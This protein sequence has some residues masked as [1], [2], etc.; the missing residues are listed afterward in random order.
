M[1]DGL[2]F[3]QEFLS[4]ETQEQE[5]PGLPSFEEE[6]GVTV[7]VA[8]GEGAPSA[9]AVLGALQRARRSL[10]L[11]PTPESK[12]FESTI[13]LAQQQAI[14]DV[15]AFGEEFGVDIE[16]PGIG[17][18]A[19]Q[20]AGRVLL[21]GEN[22]ATG[23]NKNF[24]ESRQRAITAWQ[25][26]RHV[27][28]FFSALNA[29]LSFVPGL[30]PFAAKRAIDAVIADETF[31]DTALFREIKDS[32]PKGDPAADS[33]SQKF[34]NLL[35]GAIELAGSILTDPTT[36]I[37]FGT[38]GA[39][40]LVAQGAAKGGKLSKFGTLVGKEV[41]LKK[42]GK[43]LL[44][45]ELDKLVPVL[46]KQYGLTKE[47]ADEMIRDQFANRLQRELFKRAGI[48]LEVT[49]KSVLE[50]VED[51][52]PHLVELMTTRGGNR[53]VGNFYR[54]AKEF[55]DDTLFKITQ[56]VETASERVLL[57]QVRQSLKNLNK[58]SMLERG[59]IPQGA[60]EKTIA[61]ALKREERRLIA[62]FA[63]EKAAGGGYRGMSSFAMNTTMKRGV[64]K[65]LE[66]LIDKDPSLIPRLMDF[67]GLKFF[68][69]TL[70]TTEQLAKLPFV[71]SAIRLGQKFTPFKW[72]GAIFKFDFKS[73][74]ELRFINTFEYHGPLAAAKR[75]VA[76]A[77]IDLYKT[78]D[79]DA[80]R[81]IAL[82]VEDTFE[83][84]IAKDQQGRKFLQ[85]GRV[86]ESAVE[87]IAKLA[88]E[89]QR[90]ANATKNFF[91]SARKQELAL[92]IN[93]VDQLL[94]D[95][96]SYMFKT[97]VSKAFGVKEFKE[98]IKGNISKLDLET[99][100]RLPMALMDKAHKAGILEFAPIIDVRNSFATRMLGHVKKLA[101]FRFQEAVIDKFALDAV[102]KTAT[103]GGKAFPLKYAKNFEKFD[104]LTKTARVPPHIAKAL[105]EIQDVAKRGF[106]SDESLRGIIGVVE[107]IQ[108]AHK[109]FLT[110]PFPS[111]TTRNLVTNV[112]NNVVG[113]GI[114]GLN[115]ASMAEAAMIQLSG[116]ST[117]AIKFAEHLAKTPLG[118]G[119]G[120]K[121]A[122]ITDDFGRKITYKE[123][124]ELFEETGLGMS[125]FI[126]AEVQASRKGI[127]ES[128]FKALRRGQ[129]K[130]SI[131]PGA[132]F[133]SPS[134][135]L[136]GLWS[137]LVR[138][139]DANAKVLNFVY[140]LKR[141]ASPEAA[142]EAV[143]K[144]LFDYSQITEIEKTFFR[145]WLF[146]FY[147]FSRKNI[148]LHLETMIEKPFVFTSMKKTFDQLQKRRDDEVVPKHF[149]GMP[150][151]SWTDKE[152][153]DIYIGNYGM[154]YEDIAQ[155]LNG[156][157]RFIASKL[158][159][160]GNF[161]AKLGL[162]LITMF[163]FFR[164]EKI[165]NVKSP[166]AL[167][168]LIE[169][170]PKKQQQAL[171]FNKR[172]NPQTGALEVRVKPELMVILRNLP[173][174]RI[175]TGF[176]E[177]ILYYDDRGEA[178]AHLPEMHPARIRESR[179]RTSDFT[180]AVGFFAPARVEIVTPEQQRRITWLNNIKK[181]EDELVERGILNRFELT[182]ADP[183]LPI[184]LFQEVEQ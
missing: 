40:R 70:A 184:E 173:T 50:L 174:S 48:P 141:G 46:E 72:L 32:L 67:G 175:L 182:T 165:R 41:V 78:V 19:L 115:P 109:W 177:P 59:L 7:P 98:I 92:G 135:P 35:P 137:D 108:R 132:G 124:R 89:E 136:G 110:T 52:A 84:T 125:T 148:G 112:F 147:T 151:I 134:T 117:R 103:K 76:D 34:I 178:V 168:G 17:L 1:S 99:S 85:I 16:K 123:I 167:A 129:A 149:K 49:Q 21:V 51:R 66:F 172:I 63:L 122:F 42:Q 163:D 94:F 133:I 157:A 155:F 180:K 38:S 44:K 100:G 162:E 164:G 114:H 176:V 127:I 8:E 25:E 83:S 156:D 113:I 104:F 3:E 111:F 143:R 150:Y 5:T 74:K 18:Q 69:Q 88:P 71:G 31:K 121:G 106:Y 131:R 15:K 107:G 22:I 53:N 179:R 27:D 26:G 14:E 2:S 171:G 101:D 144:F 65:Q 161:V 55:S 24:E 142:A 6:F 159:A 39:T 166:E 126:G 154:P 54:I 169:Q 77:A 153:K 87:K 86:T 33:V 20:T 47:A 80:A 152:G 64:F 93:S 28:A 9:T 57:K 160:R 128:T 90:I 105:R 145:R 29:N 140:H 10:T 61:L 60:T 97:P 58:K 181:L 139:A 116:K 56:Q 4:G 68:G 11:S 119:I 118:K 73:P 102:E 138:G 12:A 130:F 146:P 36:Y 62:A 75:R 158:V 81:R 91:D 37:T 79:D 95:Q 23:L 30:N 170:L 82:A 120:I 13:K 96:A 45:Q 43:K 183:Q